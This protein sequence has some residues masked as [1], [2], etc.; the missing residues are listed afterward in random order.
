MD[1][2]VPSYYKDFKCIASKCKHNCCIGW[3]ID[4][5]NDTLE[6]Y[7]Q[8]S[9]IIKNINLN[10]DIPHFILKE[11]DRCPF[12]NNKNLCE[13]ILNH[14]EEALCQIC[15]DHPRFVNCFNSRTETGLGLTCEAAVKLILDNDFYIVKHTESE[16]IADIDQDETDFFAYREQLFKKDIGEL[17]NLLPDISLNT[18]YD[19]FKN[20]ER[21]DN[22]W[23]AL[24]N[25][26]KD[27]KEKLAD[28]IIK[29][30]KRANKLFNYFLFRHLH[31]YG[32]EFCI[33]CTYFILSIDYDIYETARMF[34]S[35]IE[36]SDENIE[37]LLTLF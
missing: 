4:I 31:N 17:K 8:Q 26:I 18:L 22:G 10:A 1:I 2:F 7:K 16:D 19:I 21:L 6:L 32:L 24:L 34:S 30:G 15:K 29:D 11:D 13:I 35:E 5:D 3:E 12:L 25:T 20:L 23:D 27:K 28:L 36:Y 33:F 14:G 9:D 37:K